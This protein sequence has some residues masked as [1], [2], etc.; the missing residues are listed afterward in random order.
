MM[1]ALIA[2]LIRDMRIAVRVGGGALMGVL[3]FLVVVTLTPFALGPDLALLGRIGPAILWLA[4]LL[5]SLLALDRLFAADH[6]D[7][8]LDLILTGRAPLELAVAVKALAHWVTTS[9]PLVIV[10]P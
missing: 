5:A 6:D 3:F 10:A 1:R 8:S 2:V 9:L 4:A 7:G